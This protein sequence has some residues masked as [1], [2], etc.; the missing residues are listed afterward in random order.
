MMLWYISAHTNR[1]PVAHV[2]IQ[3]THFMRAHHSCKQP[4]CLAQKFVVFGTVMD[5]QAHTVEEHGAEMSSRDRKDAR[6]IEAEFE[7]EDIAVGRRRRDGNY[8][9]GRDRE[10]PPP[11]RSSQGQPVNAR[12]R[13]FGANLTSDTPSFQG[14]TSSM[15]LLP[16]SPE[17]DSGTAE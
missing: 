9:R 12:R 3:E 4:Y 5:L 2:Q 6:R 7:F 17:I 8:D 14:T 13:D 10:P 15:Q 16:A 11:A 1:W